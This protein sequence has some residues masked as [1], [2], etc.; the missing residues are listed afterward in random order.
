MI[1]SG[2]IVDI[3]FVYDR[4]CEKENCPAGGIG[5]D[6]DPSAMRL[7]DGARNRQADAHSLTFSGDERLEKLLGNLG[8]D[9]R[10][11]GGHADPDMTVAG[12]NDRDDEIARLRRFHGIHRIADQI[13]QDLLDLYAV[14]EHQIDRRVE[15]ELHAYAPI[16]DA[17]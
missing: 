9:P 16:L 5:L 14:G 4:K 6:P 15:L 13:E 7:Y 3:S 11:A 17:D 12:R 10:T 8:R 2:C 1:G